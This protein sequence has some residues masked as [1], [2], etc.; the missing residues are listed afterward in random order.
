[1]W[2]NSDV[3]ETAVHEYRKR[4]HARSIDRDALTAA[5][6]RLSHARLATFAAFALIAWLA[7]WH[8]GVSG[9]WTL[10]PIAVFLWL[11]RRHDQ[12]L[13]A[14]EHVTRGIAFY[15]RGLARIDDRW[16]GTGEPGERFRDDKHPYASDLDLFGKGSLFELLSLA[17]T[18]AGEAKLAHWLTSPA[19]A[20]EI[21]ARQSAVK[22]LA[23]ALDLRESLAFS[24]AEV[25]ASVDTDRVVAWAESSA[26]SPR[27]LHVVI[28]CFTA[29]TFLASLHA[30]FTS[31]FWPVSTLLAL[32]GLVLF[33][34]SDRLDTLL[35]S[36]EK[37]K[38]GDF[39]AGGLAHRTRDFNTIADLLGHLE[40]AR[41]E[42]TRL[43]SLRSS[44]ESDGVPASGAIR[45]LHQL[46][47]IYD[48]Q[49]N[50]AII[51]MGL[52]LMGA[53][54]GRD[55]L[56]ALGLIVAGILMLAR[57]H[58]ALAVERWR[59]HYGR[60]VRV[61]IDAIAELE[62]LCSLAGYRYEHEHDS[63]PE[64]VSSNDGRPS[65]ALFEGLQLGHP[66]LPRETM[67]ANDVRLAEDTRLLIV[68]GSN[69]SGKST[70]LRT[71]GINV[72][73]AQAGAPVRAASLR[74]SPLTI[75]ASI[76]IQ[77]SLLEGRSR[78]YAEITRIRKVADLAAG[79]V[80]VLFLLDELFS[81]T[82]S[83]DRL[84]AAEG[85]LCS[86][87]DLGAI[88]LV[89]THDLALTAIAHELAPRAVNVHFQDWFEDDAM[90]FDYRMKPG[91]VTR[92]NALA[93]M[94]AIGLDVTTSSARANR[95]QS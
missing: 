46:S 67:V 20:V 45:R 78:F 25:R 82:N 16:V 34:F 6:A 87:L 69:M 62:A 12:V 73:L 90:K 36:S 18:R 64:I 22:E 43:Q 13:R 35:S 85:V 31:I 51:P 42:G 68:S 24:G 39:L 86:L 44:L 65:A 59:A 63:F 92:S 61:W 23:P 8:S 74:L 5:D 50:A 27:M 7:S 49:K 52:I 32:Q 37:N 70:L 80:P 21:L 95:P 93:L 55:S 38:S 29:A 72:V 60:R 56:I 14:R 15:E 48:S 19:N 84:T 75:G 2:H 81:G 89:T 71:V 26:R 66:L 94:R 17:R 91:P 77:D 28:W 11:I 40:R 9:W 10:A 79:P 57:P 53:F 76:R 54:F 47:E 1:M 83:H 33:R 4:A 3:A 58:V 88:G 41:F 30:A